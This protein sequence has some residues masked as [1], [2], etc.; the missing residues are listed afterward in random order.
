MTQFSYIVRNLC[1][2]GN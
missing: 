2:M 1:S